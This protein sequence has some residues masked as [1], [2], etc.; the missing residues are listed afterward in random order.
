MALTGEAVFFFSHLISKFRFFFS[1]LEGCRYYSE[2]LGNWHALNI[3]CK[4]REDSFF[5]GLNTFLRAL[6]DKPKQFTSKV[7][8][9]RV[10]GCDEME[11]THEN[12]QNIEESKTL[13]QLRHLESGLAEVTEV[14]G[15]GVETSRFSDEREWKSCPEA[16]GGKTYEN[17]VSQDQQNQM[18]CHI[19]DVWRCQKD[20]DWRTV[21]FCHAGSLFDF[22]ERKRPY[23]W[24]A[25]V[26]AWFCLA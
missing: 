24:S 16:Q 17:R 5:I 9:F 20:E 26:R 13:N 10:K 1:L 21:G 4:I 11:K 18:L 23:G 15:A 12:C 19:H 25:G 8:K 3:L 14:W 2:Q 6:S 7:H 22:Q